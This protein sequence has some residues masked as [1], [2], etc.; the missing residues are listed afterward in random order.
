MNWRVAKTGAS[1][2]RLALKKPNTT[3][4]SVTITAKWATG[5]QEKARAG[6][7]ENLWLTGKTS[8]TPVIPLFGVAG[9]PA[10]RIRWPISSVFARR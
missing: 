6:A 10:N 9:F 5:Q 4:R 3:E 1:C 7:K 2:W 8:R